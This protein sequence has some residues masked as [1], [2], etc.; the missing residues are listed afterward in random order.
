MME[1]FFL[2]RDRKEHLRTKFVT[3]QDKSATEAQI[4]EEIPATCHDEVYFSTLP[5]R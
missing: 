5:I 2:S 4:V 1:C 3:V